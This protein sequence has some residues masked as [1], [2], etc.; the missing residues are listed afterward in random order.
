MGEPTTLEKAAAAL[1]VSI[2]GALARG[3]EHY[4]LGGK[5]LFSVE[6]VL[7]ALGRDGEIKLRD[8][9]GGVR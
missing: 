7:T 1:I 8:P 3:V 2:R 4:D 9:A 6:E 5:R